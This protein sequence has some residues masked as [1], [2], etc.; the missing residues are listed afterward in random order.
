MDPDDTLQRSRTNTVRP[1]AP[2][3]VPPGV[4]YHRVLAGDKCRIG[5]GTLAIALVVGGMFVFA[6][7][8]AEAAA[9][10]LVTWRTGGKEGPTFRFSGTTHRLRAKGPG[11]TSLLSGPTPYRT[12]L[13][14]D[15][16]FG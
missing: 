1:R 15:R 16:P 9:L 3:P 6:Y 12:H 13:P 14:P 8:L 11:P 10:A 7:R 2:R 5:R 4:E